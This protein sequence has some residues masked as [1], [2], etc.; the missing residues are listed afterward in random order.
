M[1]AREGRRPAR[2][3]SQDPHVPEEAAVCCRRPKIEIER[4]YEV[5]TI[6]LHCAK[7]GMVIGKGGEQIEQY[8]KDVE[9]LGKTVK[10][11]IVE[12]RNPDTGRSAG[13]REHRRSAG[14]A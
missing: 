10:L 4:S 6:Y 13:C 7:P 5:V 2:R 1:P 14:E 3:G 9:K 8:R 12:V 11:N